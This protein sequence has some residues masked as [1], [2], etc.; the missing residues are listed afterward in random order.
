MKKVNLILVL[1]S[2]AVISFSQTNHIYTAKSSGLW[3]AAGN[4]D[5]T[6]RTDG[7]KKNKVIVPK[8]ITIVATNDVNNLGLGDVELVVYGSISVSAG[9]NLN[10]SDNSLIQLEGG[11]I[12]GTAANQKIKIGNDIKYKGNNDGTLTGYFITDNTTGSSP[13]G[14][15]LLSILPVNFTSFYINKSGENIQLYWST[16][17]EINNSH[18]DVERSYNGTDWQKI[19]EVFG[20]RNSNNSNNYSY[21]DKTIPSS[22]IYYRLR[23]V[24]IDGRSMYSSIKAVRSGEV[25]EVVRIFGKDKKVVIDLNTAVKKNL[26][27]SVVNSN[28]QVITRQT[29]SNPSYKIEVNVSN[30]STG[31]YIVHVSDSEGWSEAKKVVL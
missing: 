23:Q 6:L 2:F 11:S 29:F 31:T 30:S 4:W 9:T 15:R 20:S 7:I 22:V 16:A 10:F 17:N 13:N 24:D 5:T 25:I 26:V 8:N 18:F 19:A 21:H 1:L 28:G 12:V 14:F 3:T 27:I